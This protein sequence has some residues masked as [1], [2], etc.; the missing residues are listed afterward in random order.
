M[1]AWYRFSVYGHEWTNDSYLIQPTHTLTTFEKADHQAQYS[2]Q[3]YEFV[4]VT[5]EIS[6]NIVATRELSLWDNYIFIISLVGPQSMVL[7]RHGGRSCL[8]DRYA[9]ARWQNH[10]ADR[11]D[12]YGCCCWLG[13]YLAPGD[14]QH[15]WRFISWRPVWRE[16][17]LINMVYFRTLDCLY[18]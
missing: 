10:V 17:P 18:C 1:S 5:F 6:R 16:L 14:L 7:G 3:K 11:V 9:S 13:A 2:L 4:K 8:D 12:L 15:P